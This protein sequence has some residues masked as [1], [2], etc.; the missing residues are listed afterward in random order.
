MSVMNK[1]CS[2]GHDH[3]NPV[4]RIITGN[5]AVNSI[6]EI[7]NELGIKKAFVVSDVNTYKAAGEKV[8]GILKQYG[9]EFINF[10]FKN[11]K[12]SPDEHH[13]GS[14]AMRFKPDCDVII[15]VGSGVINDICKIVATVSSK[16]YIIVCTAPSMDG[17]ASS[18]SSMETDGLKVS[19]PSKCADII[20]GDT[21]ILK[22]APLEMLK[23]GIGD[24]LAKYISI[25]EWRISH[26]ITGEYYCESVADE[27]RQALKKC[28]DNAKGLLERRD[29]P[30]EAVFDGL[31]LAGVAMTYAGLSRPASG[32]EHYFS[33]IWDMRGLEFGTPTG[34]HGNQCAIATDKAIELYNRIR[35][36]KPDREKAKIAVSKFDFNEYAEELRKF[37]GTGA[38]SMIALE[39]KEHKYDMDLHAERLEIII[40]NWQKIC[41]II[42]AELP[43]R[44]EFDALMSMIDFPTGFLC[45]QNTKSFMSKCFVTTKDIRDKYV[46]SRLAWD[47]GVETELCGILE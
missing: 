33:H 14:V 24:M 31:V 32:V 13:L 16:K 4:G 25:C 46:L 2:C 40:D 26:V 18:L 41:D 11:G 47:L 38:E 10:T 12:P 1:G 22:N 35:N 17:Y 7:L 23:S 43:D 34:L 20:I 19:V 44:E 37:I 15:G 36:I 21:D 6:P 3:I 45:S 42:D 8:C 29:G 28:V 5:G 27:V 39:A 30:V 9:F